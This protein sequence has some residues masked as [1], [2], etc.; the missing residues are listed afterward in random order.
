MVWWPPLLQATQGADGKVTVLISFYRV[1]L[2]IAEMHKHA[3]TYLR[4]AFCS[5]AGSPGPT[6][7][8]HAE[9]GC[10]RQHRGRSAHGNP[11]ARSRSQT[12]ARKASQITL[13]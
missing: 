6:T 3:K 9:W 7:G 5:L 4:G 1:R 13:R 8:A 10:A 12:L 11:W 2:T